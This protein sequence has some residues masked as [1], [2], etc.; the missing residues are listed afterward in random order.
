MVMQNEFTSK[1]YCFQCRRSVGTSASAPNAVLTCSAAAALTLLCH[2]DPTLPYC[3]ILVS[4]YAVSAPN[5]LSAVRDSTTVNHS[6]RRCGRG[7]LLTLF[8]SSL[9]RS[10][11]HV[12][13][14]LRVEAFDSRPGS[15]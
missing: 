1:R 11:P 14:R 10:R 12:D 2:T 13:S 3:S 6:A 8:A 9:T 7:V 4:T 15:R 5:Q